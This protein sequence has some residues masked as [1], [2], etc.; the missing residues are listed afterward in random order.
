MKSDTRRAQQKENEIG[1]KLQR[2]TTR[3]KSCVLSTVALQ[4]SFLFHPFYSFSPLIGSRLISSNLPTNYGVRACLPAFR[5]L[6]LQGPRGIALQLRG[7]RHQR[8]ADRHSASLN[9]YTNAYTH[10]H[11]AKGGFGERKRKEME[12]K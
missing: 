9:I 12:R 7:P 1:M 2:K 6:A 4:S 5:C 3:R 8:Q 11:T 10:T